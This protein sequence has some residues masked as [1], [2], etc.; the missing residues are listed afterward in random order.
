MVSG[1][2]CGVARRSV[3]VPRG[4]PFFTLAEV[5]TFRLAAL[6]RCCT[7][8]RWPTRV[9]PDRPR[10]ADILATGSGVRGAIGVRIANHAEN[11]QVMAYGRSVAAM[12]PLRAPTKSLTS[13][14]D[15]DVRL[16]PTDRVGPAAAI[17]F[18]LSARPS[19]C[20]G[21]LRSAH[22]AHGQ[23]I[24]VG[25]A[26]Q[27]ARRATHLERSS[28]GATLPTSAPVHT[29]AGEPRPPR[30][31]DNSHPRLTIARHVG[32]PESA[33]PHICSERRRLCT[34]AA[35]RAQPRAAQW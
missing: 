17:H 26:L 32:L 12:R 2:G 10:T 19:Q 35:H 30:M 25:P 1:Y 24:H 5:T 34:P 21:R 22:S 29:A 4:L 8:T 16:A 15:T 28:L 6:A 31:R 20:S 9:E 7:P 13:S 14:R 33:P 11:Q 18:L 3:R 27:G 23:A